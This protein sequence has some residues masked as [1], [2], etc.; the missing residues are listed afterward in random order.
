MGIAVQTGCSH[1]KI[2][3]NDCS[4]AGTDIRVDSGASIVR[5]IGNDAV[6]QSLDAP[7]VKYSAGNSWQDT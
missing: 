5:L 1:V 7:A 3:A 6:T 2:I 4:G